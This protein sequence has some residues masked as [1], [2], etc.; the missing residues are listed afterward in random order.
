MRIA[1]IAPYQGPGLIQRR[2][3]KSNLGLAANLKM[4]LVAELLRSRDH[5][6][7]LISQGEV[8]VRHLKIYSRFAED[9]LFDPS[10]PVTYGTAIPIR[11]INGISSALSTL[12]LFLGR[13][14]AAPFDVVVVYNLKPP[15]ILCALYAS[16]FLGL[17]VVLEHEDDAMVEVTGNTAEGLAAG[18]HR[19][20]TLRVLSSLSGCLGASPHL[21]SRAPGG[22]P[23]ALLRGVVSTNVLDLCNEPIQNRAK[24][25]VFSGTLFRTKG[26]EQ[27]VD[28]WLKVR[29][30]GWQLHVAGDGEKA[31]VLRAVSVKDKSIIFHGLLGREENAKL[32]S[33]ATIGI[34]PHDLSA[35]PGNVF[36][37]KIIEYLAAGLHVI[38]TPMGPLEKELEAGITYIP[39][40]APGTIAECLARV[41]KDGSHL[42]T[43]TK[44][45]R[46]TYGPDAVADKLDAFFKEVVEG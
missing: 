29:P 33:R 12:Q 45:A 6:V 26:L 46:H 22:V 30:A 42:P 39:D 31:D 23:K 7:E 8:V 3:I 20:L 32:L 41:L 17:P 24:W 5:S 2:P 44:A 14:S 36:A 18:M 15:Q 10:V 35:T 19:R 28:A 4:E 1:Y 34:N 13:H 25:V 43:A 38:S 9:K 11:F 16:R 21:L 40:N 37:F 27:L